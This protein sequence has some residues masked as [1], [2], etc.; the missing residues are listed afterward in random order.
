[1]RS[2][3]CSCDLAE[4]EEQEEEEEARSQ[5]ADIKPNNPHLTGGD[6]K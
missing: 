3:A 5:T 6:L 2:S 1:M 4:V